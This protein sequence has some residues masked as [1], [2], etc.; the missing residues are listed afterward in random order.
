[1]RMEQAWQS[2]PP[3]HARLFSAPYQKMR[4]EHKFYFEAWALDA[5]P[6]GVEEIA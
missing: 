2:E 3:P 6:A 4:S 1:M 5:L